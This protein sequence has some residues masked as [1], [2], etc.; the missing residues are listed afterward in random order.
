MRLIAILFFVAAC[1]SRATASDPEATGGG[2][3]EQKSKEY[4]TCGASLQ[5]QD[6]LRCFDHMCRRATRSPTGDYQAALGAQLR[7]RGELDAAIAAYAAAVGYY[8]EKVPP[9]IDCAYGATLAQARTKNDNAELAARVLHRCMLAVAGGPLHDEALLHLAELAD[10]GLDPGL[11][12]STKLADKY[13]TKGPMRP[14]ADKLTIGVTGTP[15][16]S[17]KVGPALSQ[18]LGEG[19]ARGGL[20]ACWTAYSEASKKDT[21]SVTIGARAA[22]VES[23]EFDD[24]RSFYVKVDAAPAGASPDAI[25]EGCVRKVLEPALKALK[26]SFS[27]KLTITVK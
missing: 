19:D 4:E 5:C 20:V 25:A 14:S 23:E 10:S 26:E 18:K 6:E 16:L 3:A 13:L 9:D 24:V 15:A 17:A 2:R 1:D 11:L 7:A 12:N 27:S 22:Y 8:G 21:L